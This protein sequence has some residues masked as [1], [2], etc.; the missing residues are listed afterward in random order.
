MAA[1]ATYEPIATTTLGSAASNITFSSI[2][3]TY[4]DLVL[5]L[6]VSS[7]SSNAD[8]IMELN[9][10]TSTNYSWTAIYANGSTTSSAR[11]TNY[12]NFDLNYWS[13][14]SSTYPTFY[15]VDFFSYTSSRYKTILTKSSNDF[16]G[17]GMV[18]RNV[19]LWRSTSAINTIKLYPQSPQTFSTGTIATIY[20]ITA[21]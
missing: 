17:S 4:T 16:N 12:A 3:Q 6:S 11:V 13:N 15:T 7:L 1:G 9:S 21:A 20:G 18:Y 2:P 10:D 14:N 5:I 19:G 8:I